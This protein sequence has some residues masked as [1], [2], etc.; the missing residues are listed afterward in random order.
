MALARKTISRRRLRLIPPIE[1]C[2]DNIGV[3]AGKIQEGSTSVQ[4]KKIEDKHWTHSFPR[5][6]PLVPLN[7]RVSGKTTE[8]VILGSHGITCSKLSSYLRKSV[9][10]MPAANAV[11]TPVSMV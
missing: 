3:A 4:Q 8:E 10:S 1:S 2:E 11:I 6:R 5:I 7:S 9:R